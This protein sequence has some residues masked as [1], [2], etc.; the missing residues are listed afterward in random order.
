MH[1]RSRDRRKCTFHIQE[2]TSKWIT[3]D[4]AHRLFIIRSI[5][6][7][8]RSRGLRQG[9]QLVRQHDGH[10]RSPDLVWHL[11]H[12]HP[13]LHWHEGSRNRPFNAAVRFSL[14]TVCGMVRCHQLLNYLLREFASRMRFFFFLIP[15]FDID[16]NLI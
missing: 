13:F 10:R 5:G 11:R 4:C 6:V 1:R 3:R 16:P 15:S 14:P 7:H 8:G 9:V 12:L 2:D